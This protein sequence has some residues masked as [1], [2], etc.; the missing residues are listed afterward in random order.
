MK[1]NPRARYAV[2]QWANGLYRRNAPYADG[3]AFFIDEYGEHYSG[4]FFCHF[5]DM[6]RIKENYT[7]YVSLEDNKIHFFEEGKSI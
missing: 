6:D 5:D 3:Y 2:L 1:I 7:G 4:E